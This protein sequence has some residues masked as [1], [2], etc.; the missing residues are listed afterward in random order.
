[1]TTV[2]YYDCFAGI[3]GDM[4][5]GALVDL[6]VDREWLLA[7]LRKLPIGAFELEF[8]RDSRRGVGGTKATVIVEEQ[9]GTAHRHFKDIA[10]MIKGS[11]LA[12]QVKATALK[13]FTKI[14]QAEAKVHGVSV[15]KVHFHEVG[16]IDSIVDVVGAA[17]CLDY[18]K[19]DTVWSSAVQLGSGFVK[20]AHGTLPV[21]AP[22]TAEILL[23]IPTCSGVVP[24]EATTPTGA[25][26]LAATVDKFCEQFQFVPK[27]IG[28]GI[29]QRDGEVPNVLRVF[30]AEVQQQDLAFD[31]EQESACLTECNIDDMS[32]ELYEGVMESLFDAGAQDVFFT[33]IIMK[34]SRPAV[35][36]SVICEGGK[37]QQVEE[38]L[39]LQTSTF[40]VRTY[41]ITK[42]MLRREFV[43]VDTEFGPICVKRAFYGGK[44]LKSKVEYQE[45][46]R[47][48]KEQGLSVREVREKIGR[49]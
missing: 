8:S 9:E 16:A 38:I 46:K 25:G 10:A 26:I 17:L 24:F 36:V 29:G 31:V 42:S 6:G 7:E 44:L 27:K 15:E 39:L 40:G 13:I 30:V 4:N 12:E 45:L 48:A 11:T 49:L 47:V 28:Y 14:A 43:N 19:V 22:A 20:C 34:K 21:P 5:L 1:M 37:R 35:T 2:L 41:S 18:L 33:P 23:G 3:S 32:P